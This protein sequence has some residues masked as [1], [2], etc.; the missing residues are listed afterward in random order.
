MVSLN[1]GRFVVV[2]LYSTFSRH[3]LDFY[4]KGKFMP[5]IAIFHDFWGCKPT[6]FLRQNGEIWLE[7]ADRGLRPPSQIFK[8]SLRRY[9]L[10]GTNLYQKLP[11]LAIFGL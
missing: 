11:I 3:L 1:R 10:F 4:L 9:T 2:H 7:G 8:N 5:K 6:F